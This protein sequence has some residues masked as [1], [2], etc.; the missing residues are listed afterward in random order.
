[1]L[2]YFFAFVT[3]SAL[4]TKQS[5]AAFMLACCCAHHVAGTISANAGRRKTPWRLG[6]PVTN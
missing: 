6:R 5:A 2:T 4:M 3:E 1:M